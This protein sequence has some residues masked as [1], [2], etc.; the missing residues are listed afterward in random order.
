MGQKTEKDRLGG[1]GR[2]GKGLRESVS[3]A[4][5]ALAF[6]LPLSSVFIRRIQI[7]P[8]FSPINSFS[9][10]PKQM[11]ASSFLLQTFDFEIHINRFL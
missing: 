2:Q 6:P 9:N 7:N 3:V 5:L 11:Y 8:V 10:Y 4:A 1:I